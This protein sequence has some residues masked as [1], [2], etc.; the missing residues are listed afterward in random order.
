LSNLIFGKSKNFRTDNVDIGGAGVPISGF[1]FRGQKIIEPGQGQRFAND[2]GG[3]IA[4]YKDPGGMWFIVILVESSGARAL[5]FQGPFAIMH[6]NRQIGYK[7]RNLFGVKLGK[8]GLQTHFFTGVA[9]TA[10]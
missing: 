5:Y 3:A 8:S 1:G 4:K 9:K 2:G 7:K 6:P 10:A